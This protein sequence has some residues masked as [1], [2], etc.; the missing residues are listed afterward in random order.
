MFNHMF[1]FN[2]MLEVIN[3]LQIFYVKITLLITVFQTSLAQD[4]F[5]IQISHVSVL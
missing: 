1:D 3:I 4:A 5:D 2:I